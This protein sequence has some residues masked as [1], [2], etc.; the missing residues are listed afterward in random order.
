MYSSAAI[1]VLIS[2]HKRSQ[3]AYDTFPQTLVLFN[4]CS[5]FSILFLQILSL[6]IK[7]NTLD[8]SIDVH[9]PLM[10]YKIPN[11][12]IGLLMQ[13]DIKLFIS[14]KGRDTFSRTNMEMII[15]VQHG[16][17]TQELFPCLHSGGLSFLAPLE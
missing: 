1:F 15:E 6:I 3:C 16:S 8:N 5:Y 4:N 11:L 13:L 10:N 14:A 17:H 12:A 2:L 7:T 9:I